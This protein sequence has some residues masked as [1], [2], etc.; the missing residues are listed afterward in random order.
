MV[1]PVAPFVRITQEMPFEDRLEAFNRLGEGMNQL[2]VCLDS[3]LNRLDRNIGEIRCDLTDEIERN[4]NARFISL[5]NQ[6][7][8]LTALS[9]PPD[10]PVTPAEAPKGRTLSTMSVRAALG[11]VALICGLMSSA[12]FVIK[13][14]A[15]TVGA[16]VPLF[17]K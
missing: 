2:H 3:G 4:N 16:A 15:T 1:E 10:A 9:I 14:V 11:W 5:S 13:V 6:S 12:P 7:R 8:L 17:V